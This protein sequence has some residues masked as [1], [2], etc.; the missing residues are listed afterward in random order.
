MYGTF[1]LNDFKVSLLSVGSILERGLQAIKTALQESF[2]FFPFFF[3]FFD[4]L[5][6]VYLIFRSGRS[7]KPLTHFDRGNTRN[8]W[9]LL[10]FQLIFQQMTFFF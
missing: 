5:N 3:F 10:L 4:H 7:M 6:Q 2:L 1:S 9:V 8:M